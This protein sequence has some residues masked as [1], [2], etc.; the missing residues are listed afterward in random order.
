MQGPPVL[1]TLLG[2]TQEPLETSNKDG[3]DVEVSVS[4]A[5][6]A[7][8][9]GRTTVKPTGEFLGWESPWAGGQAEDS[10]HHPGLGWLCLLCQQ[11]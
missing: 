2:S 11:W 7:P 3:V 6:L 4:A 1:H 10:L 9:A 8:P 5:S